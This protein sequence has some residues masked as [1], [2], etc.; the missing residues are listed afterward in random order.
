[1]DCAAYR[2]LVVADVH[3]ALSPDEARAAR[4]HVAECADCR[5]ARALELEVG[6]M[7][8]RP[9]RIQQAPPHLRERVV[10]AL[11][12]LEAATAAAR[13]RR[14]AGAAAVAAGVLAALVLLSLLRPARADFVD[15]I[16][17]DYRTVVAGRFA[18]DVETADP[19]ELARHFDAA[20]RFDFPAH[21][22]DMRAA[23]YRLVGG[24]VREHDG[25]RFAV[26]VYER[27]GAYVVC[28]RFR[29]AAA[30]APAG[31]YYR[32]GEVSLHVRRAG[33]VVC[34]L[35]TT[36]PR[37]DFERAVLARLG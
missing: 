36:M 16:G 17:Y 18:L 25:R 37:A 34:C 22:L 13:R 10:A 7:L 29:D 1:M 2:D 6:A 35:T 27:Q 19:G 26:A 9:R 21:V 8:R 5:N 14:L 32:R 12:R 24:A 4:G 31:A 33:G 28:H 20:G 23:G 11:A 15:P 3:G 30:G